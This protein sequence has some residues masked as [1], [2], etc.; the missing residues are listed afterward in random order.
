MLDRF[1]IL[2]FSTYWKGDLTVPIK[3]VDHR[4]QRAEEFRKKRGQECPNG[5]MS[6]ENLSV[7]VDPFILKNLLPSNIVSHRR[8]LS[9]LRVARTFADL[10]QEDQISPVHIELSKNYTLRPF[11]QVLLD[12]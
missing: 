4:V 11:N 7:G 10:E 5:R 12:Q 8:K 6:W 2:L 1:D 3:E 9:L